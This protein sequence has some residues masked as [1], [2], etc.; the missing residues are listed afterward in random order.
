MSLSP[1]ERQ[2]LFLELARA[3]NGTTAQDA[4]LA[5]QDRGDTVS[6]EAYFNLGRRLTHSG[7]LQANK[8]GGRTVYVSKIDDDAE[9]L[10]ESHIA[11][12]IDPEF[13]L[14]ALT[15]YR[16]SLRQVRDIP[17]AVWIEARERL[18]K[19]EARSL[20]VDA[21]VSYAD[22]LLCE[23]K[24]YATER[25]SAYD[26]P[27]LS[28]LRQSA[29][30]CLATLMSLCKDGL[31]LSTEAIMLPV[32]VDLASEA[33][34]RGVAP[35]QYYDLAA[36]KDEIARRVEA[37]PF[38]RLAET[39]ESDHSLVIAGV[40]GSSVGGLLSIDG[41]G[42]DFA[43]GHSPQVSINTATG[44]L[45]RDI[46]IHNRDVPAFQRL[47]EKP[48]DMQQRDNRYTIMAKMFF[49]DLTDSEYVHSTWNAMDLLECRATLNMMSRWTQLPGNVEL[50]PAD[51]VLRDGTIVPNDRDHIHYG[52]QN[53]YGRIVRDLIDV[54][55]KIAK[56]CRNDGQTVVGVVKNAQMRVLSPVIN[57]FLGQVAAA[58][59]DTQLAAWSLEDMNHLF[60]QALLSRILT[61]GRK[62]SD[63]WLRTALVLRPFHATSNLSKSYSRT[64]GSLPHDK[65]LQKAERAR[66]KDTLDVT[67]EE[68]WWRTLRGNGDSYIQMLRNVWY[69]G[70][71][72][73]AFRRLDSSESLSRM[74]F[75]V[76]HSTEEVGGFPDA[77]CQDHLYRTLAALNTVGFQ[78]DNEH[79][80]FGAAGRIDLLPTILVRSHEAVKNWGK[81]LR[82]RVSEFMDW[83]LAKYLK[84]GQKRHVKIRP[85]TRAELEAW[86]DAMQQ[87]RRLKGPD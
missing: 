14:P 31:G 49:P 74:E 60:D 34:S 33:V 36:L 82:D 20:F 9:W 87:E 79:A 37:G 40:D 59:G 64:P 32:T 65:L 71:Y 41:A 43:F 80:M 66:A 10:E 30:S 5:G 26:A 16:E 52:Q 61:A 67:P 55:W 45:N 73:G 35:T 69:A 48:E 24:D 2:I 23:V 68:A 57:Y 12:I 27:H 85:W 63:P 54:S 70:F 39:P 76:P 62:N 77:T 8:A 17:E 38:V 15:A 46:R 22:N 53:T 28:N 7:K 6:E 13:P 1:Q 29:E 75:I 18:S 44:V 50:P 56:N 84:A 51:V 58:S 47:P 21:I 19:T 83:Q 81:Q 4:Y 3:P 25:A 78:V 86:V 72:L 42:G 11:S